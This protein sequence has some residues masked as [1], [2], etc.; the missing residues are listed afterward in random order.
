MAWPYIMNISALSNGDLNG[1]DGWSGD[2]D[3]DVQATN[4]YVGTK[5]IFT[6]G[7]M[8]GPVVRTITGTTEYDNLYLAFRREGNSTGAN[9]SSMIFKFRDSAVRQLCY[10]GLYDKSNSIKI[11]AATGE[12]ELIISDTD[13]DAWYVVQM[14]FNTLADG[15][16][17]FRCRKSTDIAWGSWSSWYSKTDASFDGSIANI[18][19]DGGGEGVDCRFGYCSTVDPFAPPFQPGA[20]LLGVLAGA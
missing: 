19:L 8:S 4:P 20:A 1:Q 2:T 10:V 15:K 16:F 3:F 13:I 17:R 7:V 12:G 14:Q 18:A 5:S 11:R 9:Q 6:S